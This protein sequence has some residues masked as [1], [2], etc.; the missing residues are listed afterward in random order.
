LRLQATGTTSLDA[1]SHRAQRV[2]LEAS[3]I[4]Q[5]SKST[6]ER[7]LPDHNQQVRVPH[8]ITCSF[9]QNH[10]LLFSPPIALACY[11]TPTQPWRCS[12]IPSQL[13]RRPDYTFSITCSPL[14]QPLLCYGHNVVC[15]S[16]FTQ[17]VEMTNNNRSTRTARPSL[18]AH[19]QIYCATLAQSEHHSTAPRP[20][21]LC[22]AAHGTAPHSPRMRRWC[23]C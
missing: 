15:Y 5:P 21:L 14:R 10:C 16:A 7:A 2:M 9:Y 12:T 19:L 22:R 3:F 4:S 23:R 8:M 6:C 18:S 11:I 20:I 13:D 17:N 1:T